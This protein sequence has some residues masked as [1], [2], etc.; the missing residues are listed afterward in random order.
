M[1]V[2]HLQVVMVVGSTFLSQRVIELLAEAG[3]CHVV[4]VDPTGP[5]AEQESAPA[6]AATETETDLLEGLYEPAEF[7]KQLDASSLHRA[8]DSVFE[9]TVKALPSN[10]HDVSPLAQV[11][12]EVKPDLLLFLSTPELIVGCNAACLLSKQPW[13]C[14]AANGFSWY[15]HLLRPGDTACMDC[16]PEDYEPTV[17]DKLNHLQGFSKSA[18]IQCVASLVVETA[19]RYLNGGE[20]RFCSISLVNGVSSSRNMFPNPECISPACQCLQDDLEV[21]A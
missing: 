2:C 13:V 17:N 8:Q 6:A 12:G 4:L 15:M 10:D 21:G 7:V 3:T 20:T 18:N 5:V 9:V 16:E 1:L 14:A 11:I 19:I